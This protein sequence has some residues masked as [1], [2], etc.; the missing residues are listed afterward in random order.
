MLPTREPPQNKK[1][2]HN[3][4]EGLEKYIPSKHIGKNVRIAILRQNRLQNKSHKKRQTRSLHNTEG[5][6]SSRRHKY[7]KYICT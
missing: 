1:P 7:Y 3:E 5:K 2:T 6:N 4:S